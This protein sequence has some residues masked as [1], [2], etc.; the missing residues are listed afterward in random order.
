VLLDAGPGND[1]VNVVHGA[2]DRVTCDPGRDIVVADATERVA[3]D[4]ER[5]Q[6]KNRGSSSR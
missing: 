6:R 3:P 1:R 5:V 4:C 2:R